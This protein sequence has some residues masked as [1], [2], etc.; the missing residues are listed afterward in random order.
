MAK[1]DQSSATASPVSEEQ[2]ST[3]PNELLE[4]AAFVYDFSEMVPMEPVAILNSKNDGTPMFF[5]H[6]L[7]GEHPWTLIASS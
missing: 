1:D 2:A 5:I 4:A 3:K 7:A 6:P